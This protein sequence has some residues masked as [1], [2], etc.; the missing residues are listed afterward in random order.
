MNNPSLTDDDITTN[1]MLEPDNIPLDTI[2]YQKALIIQH[3]RI[4]RI[5]AE[6]LEGNPSQQI[7]KLKKL[8]GA[9]YEMCINVLAEA[10]PDSDYNKSGFLKQFF[11]WD[12]NGLTDYNLYSFFKIIMEA[13]RLNIIE[14]S[15]LGMK[16][17]KSKPLYMRIEAEQ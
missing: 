3:M 8:Y 11:E 15:K 13:H 7:E 17:A 9:V 2:I 6:C 5:S 12:L 1:Q 14:Y 4:Q 10:K 16:K